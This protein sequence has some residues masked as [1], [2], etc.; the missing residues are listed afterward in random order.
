MLQPEFQLFD[1]ASQQWMGTAQISICIVFTI[2]YF[3]I[4]SLQ[5]LIELRQDSKNK[6]ILRYIGK[7]SPQIASLVKQQIIIKLTMPMTMALLIFLFCVPLLNIKLNV[8]LPAA[9]HN[10]LFKF[11]G[12]F[13]L[14]TL[15]FYLCYFLIVNAMSKQYI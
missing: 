2:I 8:I 11:T 10:V 9:L 5:Q 12:E 14:C 6:K 7:S 15:C 1:K 4:L 3:S 13:F